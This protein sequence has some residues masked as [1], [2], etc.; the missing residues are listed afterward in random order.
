MNEPTAL[1]RLLLWIDAVGGYLICPSD[2]VRFGQAATGNPVEVPLMADISRHQLTIRRDAEGYVAQPIRETRL[3]GRPLAQACALSD[4][5]RLGLGP[6]EICFRRPHA[7]SA[8]ARVELADSH[9]TRPSCDAVLLL[10]ESCVLGPRPNSHIVCRDWPQ[11]VVLFRQ[12]PTLV[13]LAPGTFEID[14][15]RCH[16]R[17]PLARGSRVAGPG[18]SFSLEDVGP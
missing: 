5:D 6:V 10:A 11:D 14:G 9:R 12:G 13:C 16:D 18:F 8:T 7:L 1:P 2:A 15:R 3:N 4:G 17:G